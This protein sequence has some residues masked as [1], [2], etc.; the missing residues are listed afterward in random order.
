MTNQVTVLTPTQLIL[1]VNSPTNLFIGKNGAADQTSL[2]LLGVFSGPQTNNV[3]TFG[4][5]SFGGSANVSVSSAGAI[6]ALGPAGTYGISATYAGVSTNLNPAGSIVQFVSPPAFP[7]LSVH[8][9]DALPPSSHAMN[10]KYLSGAPGV[11]VGYWNN[12]IFNGNT[13]SNQIVNPLDSLGNILTNV[14]VQMTGRAA[15]GGI[16]VAAGT[17]TTN[18]SVLFHTYY[19]SGLTLSAGSNSTIDLGVINISNVP[20]ASYDVYFYLE[21]DN[22]S[23]NRPGHF[24]IDGVDK[25]RRNFN[26]GMG[27]QDYGNGVG[28]P[29]ETNGVAYGYVEAVNITSTPVFCSQIAGG[30]YVKFANITDPNL[31]VDWGAVY[32]DIVV[33]CDSVTRM[34]LTGF[35]I[36]NSISGLTATNLYL[37]TPLPGLLPGSGSTFPLVV[38]ADFTTGLKGGNVTALPG[39]SFSSDNTGIFTV[40]ANGV[41]TPTST[42][43]TAH[44]IVHYTNATSNLSL[45]QAVT[46]L[47]PV[48]VNVTSIP[49]VLYIDS[50]LGPQTAQAQVIASFVGYTNVNVSSYAT[51]GYVDQGSPVVT[52]NNTTG[53]ITPNTKGT[54]SL[55]ATYLGN[56]YVTANAITVRSINDPASLVHRYP[57]RDAPGSSMVSDIVGGANGAIIPPILGALPIVL[58]GERANFPGGSYSNAAYINLPP[59]LIGSMSDV[60]IQVWGGINTNAPWQ[61]FFGAGSTPKGTDPHNLGG[62]ATS[63]L[64]LIADYGQADVD[65]EARFTAGFNE[66]RTGTNLVFGTQYQL[67]FVYAP[68]KGI[69]KAY[70]NGVPNGSFTPTNGATLST[71][72]D[73]VDWVGISLNNNDSPLNGWVDDLSIYEGAFSDADVASSFAAG[74]YQGLVPA[75]SLAPVKLSANVSSGALHLTW[76]ADHQGWI[77]QTNASGLASPNSW[78]PY[79]GSGSGTT[80]TFPIDSTKTNVFFRLVAP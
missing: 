65:M 27:A 52:M 28:N 8:V 36:V 15:G 58:D 53:V 80:Q 70:I 72:N 22:A 9:T 64:E 7:A 16:A 43:G 24:V 11:R 48:A 74:A 13:A 67:V 56:T 33:D 20:Y 44:L 41:I 57:F 1:S 19:D 54:A 68:N 47:A 39:T 10:F 60:T 14:V 42:P 40:D 50:V 73:Q 35:Q 25:Y 23:T 6:A 30:N 2:Q 49:D 78:F 29:A 59:G 71:L 61:R 51:I 77:L 38:L 55:G 37:Q 34:R 69:G 66:I 5:T 76:P 4:Q 79:P 26:A 46:V 62:T 63:A 3:T 17:I 45:T 12:M 21:N 18:E 31:H 32:Q 75:T